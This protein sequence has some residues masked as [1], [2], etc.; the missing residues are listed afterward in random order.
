MDSNKL[1]KLSGALTCLQL[2]I[3]LVGVGTGR[4]HNSNYLIVL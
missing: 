2:L 4:K 3:S 1:I